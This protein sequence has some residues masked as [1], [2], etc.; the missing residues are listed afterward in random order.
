M[1]NTDGSFQLR[2]SFQ[3]VPLMYTRM[4]LYTKAFLCMCVCILLSVLGSGQ[5][6][7]MGCE[8]RRHDEV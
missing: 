3:V 7:K 4:Y 6:S 8:E 5:S 2:S 1:L